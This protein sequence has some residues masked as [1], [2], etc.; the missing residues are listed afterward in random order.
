[1]SR[2]SSARV[3]SND[4][5]QTIDEMTK[6]GATPHQI[7][8]YLRRRNPCIKAVATNIYNTKANILK[9]SLGGRSNIQVLLEE[10]GNGGFLFDVLKDEEDHLTHVCFAHP[11]SVQ[12]SRSYSNVFVMDCTYKTNR[13][14]MPLLEIIRIR[15]FNTSFYFCF[16]FLKSERLDDYL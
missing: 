12:L 8:S 6:S 3:L 14:N 16:I 5:V 7:M 2:H 1:M 11:N 10:L 15:S 4:E 9:A 13:Y